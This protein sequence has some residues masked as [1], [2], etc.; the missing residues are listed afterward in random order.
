MSIQRY[1]IPVE[2]PV[3]KTTSAIFEWR[4]IKL[5]K[6]RT[7]SRMLKGSIVLHAVMACLT[8][9]PVALGT[10]AARPYTYLAFE[11]GGVKGI[12]YGGTSA[13]LECDDVIRGVPCVL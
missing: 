2:H 8:C 13:T 1:P 7:D 4:K 5:L 9:L 11:G 12:A 10:C 6:L 3:T